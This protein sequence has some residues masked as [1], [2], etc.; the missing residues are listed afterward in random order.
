MPP[1]LTAGF[2]PF[3]LAA[4]AWAVLAMAAWLPFLGGD[5]TLPTRFDPVT[6][7][8]HEM[9]FGFV[10]AAVGGFL[11]T[12]IPNWTERAPIAG[13]QLAVL[14]ALWLLGRIACLASAWLPEWLVALVDLAFPIALATVAARE[15][16][17]AGNRRNYPLL[18]PLI[19]L[20]AANLLVHLQAVQAGW[21]LGIATIIVL[22]AVIGGRVVPAFTRNW[23]K[24]RGATELPPPPGIVDHVALAA[25]TVAMVVWV[26]L[27][28]WQPVGV[29]LLAASALHLLRLARWQGIAALAEPLLLILHLGYLW[30][31]T[32]VGLLGLS[33]LTDEVPIAAALHALTAGAMGSMI[34]AMMPRVTLGHTGREL[35]AD[36]A[37]SV[38]F[39]VVNVAAVL[40]VA[41]AWPSDMQMDLLEV[42]TLA[43]VGAFVLFLAD[44]GLMLLAP[45]P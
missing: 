36:L 38:M 18:V 41:A 8:I 37:T 2:R 21:R 25:L 27:P 5:L 34:L 30:L 44:Y 10:M 43:W 12:A 17:A 31:V 9:L 11:L 45:R 33:L 3:F 35:R 13:V 32:G 1:L 19:A 42:A 40:R 7:H 26:C 23:L 22:I 29:L 15:L 16:V 39:A 20:A 4:A 28:D 24:A 14:V 6:W